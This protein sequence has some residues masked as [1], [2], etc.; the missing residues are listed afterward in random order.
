[1]KKINTRDRLITK[2]SKCHTVL[3]K[4][5]TFNNY[6]EKRH[7]CKQ[8]QKDYNSNYN[9]AN[10]EYVTARTYL[11][12]KFKR[13]KIGQEEYIEQRKALRIQYGVSERRSA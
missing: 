3:K 8:C 5:N 2:C 9:E 6:I 7:L 13:N 11:Y 1:M 12:T 10:R 4:S